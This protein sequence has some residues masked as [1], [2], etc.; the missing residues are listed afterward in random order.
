M[1]NEIKP[2]VGDVW[3]KKLSKSRCKILAIDSNFVW[4]KWS[5]DKD[6][7]NPMYANYSFLALKESHIL[8]ERDGEPYPPKKEKKGKKLVGCLCKVWNNSNPI[9]ALVQ[10][11]RNNE[12][13]INGF[14]PFV[15][16]EA[17]TKEEILKLKN[18]EERTNNEKV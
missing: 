8:I 2:Q 17:L 9:I 11:Y 6:R 4:T 1:I 18:F 10:D 13:W 3:A 5:A 16:A 15:N 12:Y 7:G 14:V